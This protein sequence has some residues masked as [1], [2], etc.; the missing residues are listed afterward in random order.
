MIRPRRAMWDQRN[1]YG[2]HDVRCFEMTEFQRAGQT[3]DIGPI[4][5]DQREIDGAFAESGSGSQ[6]ILHRA[7]KSTRISRESFNK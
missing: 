1:A 7:V 3:D 4:F 2:S 6:S 5:P